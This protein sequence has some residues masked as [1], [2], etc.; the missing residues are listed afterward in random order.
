M[1]TPP[2]LEKLVSASEDILSVIRHAQWHVPDQIRA[3]QNIP[4]KEV[5][6]KLGLELE[7]LDEREFSHND[8]E[9][10]KVSI[11]INEKTNDWYFE[12]VP[13]G[14]D[15]YLPYDLLER[16]TVIDLVMFLDGCELYQAVLFLLEK[17]PEYRIA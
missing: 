11:S 4:I 17:F 1:F 8:N 6:E 2:S 9:W 5:A 14:M 16:K 10:Q 7:D 3:L 12:I 15:T 13:D